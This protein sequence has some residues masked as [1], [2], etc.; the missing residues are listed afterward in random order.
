MSS[1]KQMVASAGSKID[2]LTERAAKHHALVANVNAD[3]HSSASWKRDYIGKAR[4]QFDTFHREV[5]EE[6]L[7]ALQE[8]HERATRRLAEPADEATETRKARAAMPVSRLIDSGVGP[9]EAAEILAETGD[10]DGVLAL[11]DEVPSWVRTTLPESEQVCRT[12]YTEAALL[13]VDRVLAPL[14]TGDYAEAI[15]VRLEVDREHVRLE[16][17]TD[18]ALHESPSSTLRLAYANADEHR[19]R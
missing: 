17:A 1:E 6:V 11:R 15:A 19:T 18:H 5:R 9:Q 7:G 8:A 12:R 14:V 4:D 16:A 10:V 13:G 2:G 3:P